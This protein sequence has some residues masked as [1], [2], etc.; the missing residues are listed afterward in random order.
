MYF[1]LNPVFNNTKISEKFFSFLILQKRLVRYADNIILFHLYF[2][3][4]IS[5]AAIKYKVP[6]KVHT[7]NVLF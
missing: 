3:H 7:L 5:S 2:P 1:F 4:H 6:N